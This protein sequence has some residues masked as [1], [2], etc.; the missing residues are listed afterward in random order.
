MRQIF[1]VGH[2]PGFRVALARTIQDQSQHTLSVV[3]HAGWDPGA[4]A[5]ISLAQ[6]DVVILVVGFATS[7]ALGVVSEIRRLAPAC[8]VLV[9]DALGDAAIWPAGGWG[10]ADALLRSEQLATELVP[11]ICRLVAQR[12]VASSVVGGTCPSPSP[13]E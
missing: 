5:G 11:T 6:P 2:H 3:G 4:L 8:R 7:S 10:L 12:G 9:I 1:L 13:A